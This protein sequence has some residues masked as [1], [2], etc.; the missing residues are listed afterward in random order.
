MIDQ[1]NRAEL[2]AGVQ[3]LLALYAETIDEDRLE[4]WPDLFTEKCLYKVIARENY[5]RG[6]PL[7]PIFCD[8]R[9]M[10]VDRIVSLRQANIFPLHRYRHVVGL[11]RITGTTDGVIEARTS[12]VVFQTRNDGAT[13]I[14]N[15]GTYVDEIVREGG[16]FRFRSKLV[17]F[18][19]DRVDTLMVRPI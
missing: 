5:D 10:L 12:Y 17:I 19:T 3:E 8:S 11:P 16:E 4:E 14:Y 13:T 9:G 6:L 2:Y 18:D 15:A 7:A 1:M